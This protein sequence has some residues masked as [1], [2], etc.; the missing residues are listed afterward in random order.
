MPTTLR[1]T[2]PAAC[3]PERQRELMGP[4]APFEIVEA[5]VMG[6]RHEVFVRALPAPAQRSSTTARPAT[7]IART[8]STPTAP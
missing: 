3:T 8:S 4:G 2:P 7:A 1:W 5:D 6:T